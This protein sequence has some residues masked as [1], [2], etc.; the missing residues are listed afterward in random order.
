MTEEII[1]NIKE[2]KT[3]LNCS[4]SF[5]RKLITKNDIPFIKIGRKIL[6]KK[7]SIDIWISN[8]EKI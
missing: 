8:Y 1:L 4:E 5:I 3:Y 7:S 6:F 2:L